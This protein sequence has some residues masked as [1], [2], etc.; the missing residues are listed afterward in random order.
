MYLLK[1][2]GNLS[3]EFPWNFMNLSNGW[4]VVQ[5]RRKGERFH[6]SLFQVFFKFH[7]SYY[8]QKLFESKWHSVYV[9]HCCVF[10]I[11]I[12]SLP[13]K[14]FFFN[15]FILCGEVGRNQDPILT[16]SRAADRPQKKEPD[17]YNCLKEQYENCI[18]GSD[19]SRFC[20]LKLTSQG[21]QRYCCGWT[22]DVKDWHREPTTVFFS[23]LISPQFMTRGTW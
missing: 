20:A 19:I 11:S 1:S 23:P 15:C 18:S 12:L 13:R 17:Y 9:H 22:Y 8:S 14:F 2:S 5:I 6:I 10:F 16:A 7:Y 21:D 3:R 4:V